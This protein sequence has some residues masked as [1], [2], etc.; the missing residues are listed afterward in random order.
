[1]YGNPGAALT[2]P[3]QIPNFSDYTTVNPQYERYYVQCVYDDYMKT[4]FVI[5]GSR[6]EQETTN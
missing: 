4:N 6:D 2:S 5:N 1:M 3:P